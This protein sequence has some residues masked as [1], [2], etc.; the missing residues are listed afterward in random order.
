VGLNMPT[1]VLYTAVLIGFGLLVGA[2]SSCRPVGTAAGRRPA[3]RDQPS[4]SAA[5]DL[6]AAARGD[7]GAHLRD[8][9]LNV[10]PFETGV[11]DGP[12]RLALRA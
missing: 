8:G 11:A 9:G 2:V 10:H 1:S 7:P 3:N 4:R 5:G 12:L 6:L